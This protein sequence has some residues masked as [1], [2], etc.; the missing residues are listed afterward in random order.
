MHK[1]KEKNKKEG[2]KGKDNN[3]D[4]ICDD[5][6]KDDDDDEDMDNNDKIEFSLFDYIWL[7]SPASKNEIIHLFNKSRKRKLYFKF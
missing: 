3:N 6:I 7:F 5:V 4:I 1:E 2:D